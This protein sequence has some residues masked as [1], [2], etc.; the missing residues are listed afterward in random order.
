[1]RPPQYQRLALIVQRKGTA[2]KEIER[3]HGEVKGEDFDCLAVAEERI[4]EILR[5]EESLIDL[6]HAD[7]YS[8]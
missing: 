6:A 7:P 8:P 1:M 2:D 3:D 5:A 4:E